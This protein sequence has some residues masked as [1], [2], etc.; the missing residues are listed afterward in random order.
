MSIRTRLLA[1]VALPLLLTA[2]G[3]ADAGTQATSAGSSS[4]AANGAPPKNAAMVCGDDVRGEI[5]QA[6]GIAR[7]P[8]T[9]TWADP[10]YTCRYTLPAGTLVLSV[11]VAPTKAAAGSYFDGRQHATPGATPQAGLGERSFGTPGGIVAVVKDDMT[12]TVDASGMPATFGTNQQERADFAY[13]V[14]SIVLGCWTGD[15]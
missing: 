3:A 1:A 11:N 10:V 4:A 13:E 8:A 5:G 2:C 14:A 15:S 12:L 9:P 6:L 7:P